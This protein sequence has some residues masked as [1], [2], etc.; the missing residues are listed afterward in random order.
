VKAALE[1]DITVFSYISIPEAL[2]SI[3]E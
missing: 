3:Y 1:R 2:R